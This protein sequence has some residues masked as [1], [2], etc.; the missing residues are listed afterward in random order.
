ME[1]RRGHDH[2]LPA[3]GSLL[4]VGAVVPRSSTIRRVLQDLDPDAVEAAMRTWTLAQLADRP[5]PDGVPAREYKGRPR[6]SRATRPRV[7][8]GRLC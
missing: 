8:R 4:G 7:L 6:N 5:A 2:R 3:R 1:C